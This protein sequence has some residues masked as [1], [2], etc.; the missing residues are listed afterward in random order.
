M[1]TNL[2]LGRCE[3]QL[4]GMSEQSVDVVVTSPPYNL[5]IRYKGYNDRIAE[6]EYLEQITAV[7]TQLHRVLKEDGSFFLNIAG[8][9]QKP[10]VPHRLLLQ[11]CDSN[12]GWVLQNTFI[13]VKSAA[14]PNK[15]GTHTTVG[16]FKPI[17]S[18]RF[19][20]DCHEFIFH[21]TKTGNVPLNRKAAGVPYEDKSN[22]TRWDHTGGEDLRCRGNIWFIPYKTIKSRDSDRP[23]PASFPSKLAETAMLL[24]NRFGHALDPYNGIGNTGIAAKKLG[25]KNYT[26]MDIT[27]EY[28][29]ESRKQIQATALQ[30]NV[31]RVRV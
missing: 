10:L 11:I 16:H 28:L 17:N 6:K 26:G 5:G 3:D 30:T 22:L 8:S 13:W 31:R 21:L 25:F 24:H 1:E 12:P 2:L 9:P 4:L 15:E 23:H 14:V 20:N 27:P 29:E 7:A 18:E 19:V